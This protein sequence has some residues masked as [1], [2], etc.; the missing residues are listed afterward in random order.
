MQLAQERWFGIAR[1]VAGQWA[2]VLVWQQLPVVP[3]TC[4]QCNLWRACRLHLEVSEDV[5][6]EHLADVVLAPRPEQWSTQ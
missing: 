1:N 5:A 4:K 3:Q 2:A 6:E